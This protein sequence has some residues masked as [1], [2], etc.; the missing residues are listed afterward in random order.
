M[1]GTYRIPEFT[2]F[3]NLQIHGTKENNDVHVHVRACM[4][5]VFSQQ[6]DNMFVMSHYIIKRHTYIYRL[7][8]YIS[9]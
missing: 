8:V 7:H 4:I 1:Y 9:L 3:T 6:Y 2:Y 5:Q